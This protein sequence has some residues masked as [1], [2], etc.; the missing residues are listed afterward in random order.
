MKKGM[1]EIQNVNH[2]KNRPVVLNWLKVN[3]KDFD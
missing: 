2:L 3:E 1:K